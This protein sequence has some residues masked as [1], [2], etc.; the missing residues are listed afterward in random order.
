MIVKTYNGKLNFGNIR[1]HSYQ[2]LENLIDVY[3]DG[4]KKLREVIKRYSIATPGDIFPNSSNALN[5]ICAKVDELV[6]EYEDLAIDVRDLYIV[7]SIINDYY[8][9]A[10]KGKDK[11]EIFKE[12][13]VDENEALRKELGI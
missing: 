4:L 1:V 9:K 13:V 7:S 10:S 12:I 5:E 6:D 8:I 11:E 2:E 3:E